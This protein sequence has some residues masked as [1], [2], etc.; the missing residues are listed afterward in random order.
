M[1]FFSFPKSGRL[2]LRNLTYTCKEEDIQELFE[3]YGLL[4]EVHLPL[5]KLTNKPTGLAF[6]TFMMPEHAV[7]AF[8]ELDGCVFQGRLLHVLPAK[9]KKMQEDGSVCKCHYMTGIV[10]ITSFNHCQSIIKTNS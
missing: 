3:K 9:A 8:N 1:F 5:D 2:F 10:Y 7:K 4:S 6:V